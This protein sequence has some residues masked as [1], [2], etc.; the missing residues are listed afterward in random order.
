MIKHTGLL[1]V[2]WT[3][4]SPSAIAVLPALRPEPESF[5]RALATW[6]GVSVLGA[7][8]GIVLSGIVT[9][10]LPWRVMFAVPMPVGLLGLIASARIL[11]QAA[12]D[13]TWRPR[14][15]LPG[16]VLAT[17]LRPSPKLGECADRWWR[18]IGEPR[19]GMGCRHERFRMRLSPQ[20]FIDACDEA[21]EAVPHPP[22]P[23]ENR[24]ERLQ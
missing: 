18:T 13:L 14:L 11:P 1:A 22:L 16:A 8:L 4:R 21:A 20:D 2:L 5:G 6:G 3:P 19:P 9:A 7:I 12:P 23:W 17:S 24:G 15:D 10:W